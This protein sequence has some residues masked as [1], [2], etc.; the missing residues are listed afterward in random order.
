MRL[1]QQR[2]IPH[3]FWYPAWYVDSNVST[4]VTPIPVRI[5]F[6]LKG[7]PSNSKKTLNIWVKFLSILCQFSYIFFPCVVKPSVCY[8]QWRIWFWPL[9]VIIRHA[10][11]CTENVLC[12][13]ASQILLFRIYCNCEYLCASPSSRCPRSLGNWKYWPW[14]ANSRKLWSLFRQK[15]FQ[16]W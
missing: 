5:W 13:K 14:S 10:G 15:S 3:W 1:H 8:K 2:G 11:K 4:Q 16:A 7:Q 9:T 12:I 6:K